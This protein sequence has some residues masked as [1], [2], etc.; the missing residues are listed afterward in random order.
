MGPGS[1]KQRNIIFSSKPTVLHIGHGDGAS[2]SKRHARM[3]PAGGG[4]FLVDNAN[5]TTGWILEN[6]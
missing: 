2:P 6:E 1:I 4:T 3:D 5:L